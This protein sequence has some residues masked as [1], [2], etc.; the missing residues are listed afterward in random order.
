LIAD[1]DAIDWQ[2]VHDAQHIGLSAGAS[3]PESLVEE[4]VAALRERYQINVSEEGKIHEAVNFKLP[5]I[6]AS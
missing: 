3:A 2:L 1:K 5:A 4:V 6:V